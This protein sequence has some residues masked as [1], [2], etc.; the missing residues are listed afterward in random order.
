MPKTESLLKPEDWPNCIVTA[1]DWFYGPDGN[2]YKAVYGQVYVIET[3]K[4]IGF[5]PEGGSGVANYVFA[6][7]KPGKQIIL[8]GCRVHYVTM[9]PSRPNSTS[10]LDLS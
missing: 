1:D 8:A 4:L 7:G 6:V 2:T 5:K 3:N 10:I 9:C